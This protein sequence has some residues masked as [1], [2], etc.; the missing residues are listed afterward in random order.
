MALLHIS[1]K[2]LPV[3]E[4]L[5]TLIED[6]TQEGT[7][8]QIL[9][10]SLK[11]QIEREKLQPP[12]LAYL[13]EAQANEQKAGGDGSV[14]LND[15]RGRSTRKSPSDS[16]EQVRGKARQASYSKERGGR[17][18]KKIAKRPLKGRTAKPTTTS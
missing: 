7:R 1:S 18:T 8:G 4:A 10:K 2:Y 15:E 14:D 9:V 6:H 11:V 17:R 16:Q 3:M 13:K 12:Y 5:L